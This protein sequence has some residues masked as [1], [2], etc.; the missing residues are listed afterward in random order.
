MSKSAEQ[1]FDAFTEEERDHLATRHLT[2]MTIA[3]KCPTMSL[4][5]KV[6][7]AVQQGVARRS[8]NQQACE[9]AEQFLKAK[10][11][12]LA[13]VSSSNGT[14]ADV[15]NYARAYRDLCCTEAL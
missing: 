3:G 9:N 15:A 7:E 11:K 13:R 14:S 10:E 4:D 2:T 8:K 5:G 12:L 6:F 1:F